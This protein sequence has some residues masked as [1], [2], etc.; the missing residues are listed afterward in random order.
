MIKRT[1]SSALVSITLVIMLVI[2]LAVQTAALAQHEPIDISARDPVILESITVSV[3]IPY[4]EIEI[5][6]VWDD[7]WEGYYQEEI[8]HDKGD[9]AF[10]ITLTNVADITESWGGDINMIMHYPGPL[11][12]STG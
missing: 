8:F 12:S 3:T 9:T 5:E 10:I 2:G 1:K 11:L 4:I 6:N 7:E